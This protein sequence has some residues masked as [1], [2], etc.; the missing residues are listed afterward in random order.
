LGQ[1]VSNF[2][3]LSSDEQFS[4]GKVQ[5]DLSDVRPAG[6]E[7][8]GA[9]LTLLSCQNSTEDRVHLNKAVGRQLNSVECCLLID[10]VLLWRATL[11]AR[12]E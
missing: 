5:I 3:E 1:V 7:G 8:F 6:E 4:G 12:L 2:A 10:A 11:S 9:L